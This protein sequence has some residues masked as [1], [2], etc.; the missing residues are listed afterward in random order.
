MRIK[1]ELHRDVAY[2][3]RHQFTKEDR[4]DFYANLRLLEY[5]P[6]KH[7]EFFFD[8]EVSRYALRKFRFGK[9]P[10]RIAIFDYDVVGSR[11]QVIKC[12]YSKPIAQRGGPDAGQGKPP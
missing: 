6:I 1:V 11:I 5:E 10:E 9:G 2:E 4:R 3:L 12:R 8:A 7:S